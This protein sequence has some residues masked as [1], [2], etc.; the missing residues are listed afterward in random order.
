LPVSRRGQARAGA[1]TQLGEAVLPVTSPDV[2][3][4]AAQL[5]EALL[6]SER[7]RQQRA[8]RAREIIASSTPTQWVLDQLRDAAA[9]RGVSNA[10]SRPRAL[11]RAG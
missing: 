11:A 1:Y 3:E 10:A 2:E 4:T 5:Y 9:V 8:A 7:E 6:M